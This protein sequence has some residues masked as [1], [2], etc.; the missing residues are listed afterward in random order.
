MSFVV[1]IDFE[2]CATR[3][4]QSDENSNTIFFFNKETLFWS[5]FDELY[6]IIFFFYEFMYVWF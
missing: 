1:F 2:T 6:K 3:N 5:V 4:Q